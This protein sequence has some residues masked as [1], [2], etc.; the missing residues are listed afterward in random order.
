MIKRK[1]LRMVG[2]ICLCVLIAL[3]TTT[4]GVSGKEKVIK[5][6]WLSYNLTDDWFLAVLRFA[7]DE[8]RDIEKEEGVKFEFLL[9][10]AGGDLQTQLNQADDMIT[11]GPDILYFEPIN[12]KAMASAVKKINRELGIPIGAAGITASGGEYLYVGL[13]NVEATEQCGEALVRLLTEKYGE[14]K[15]WVKAGGIIGEFWGPPGLKITQDRHT[16]FRKPLDP[17]LKAT[18]GLQIV[19][20][21]DNWDPDTAFKVVSD[22]VTRYGDKIIGM[23]ADDDTT[24]TEGCRRALKLAG[25]AYP[26]GH[27]KHIPIVTYDA[28][29]NGMRRFRDKWI[30]MITVQPA[31]GYG[32]MVMRYLYKWHKEGKESLP[33]PGTTISSEELS[34]YFDY[35]EGVQYWTPVKVV[36]GRDWDGIWIQPHS[37]IVPDEVPPKARY[38][39]GNYVY[40]MR[41]GKYEWEK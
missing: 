9:R 4:F 22:V 8:A 31:M 34:R 38:Q 18:A 39:W 37:G 40:F 33:K 21:V 1:A 26:V 13:D 6:A 30:D 2:T 27:P 14:P 28:T 24:A 41:E 3:A 20:R 29:E 35:T 25:L 7:Q 36:K 15:N 12:E 17:I 16:G 5:V 19:E 23:Y 32:H 11:I 10:D